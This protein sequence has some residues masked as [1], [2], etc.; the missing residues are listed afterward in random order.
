LLGF[1]SAISIF[2]LINERKK[3]N[4]NFQK[5]KLHKNEVNFQVQ[6]YI[7]RIGP[8]ISRTEN[9]SIIAMD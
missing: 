2:I 3:W 9:I 5:Q 8:G 1:D 7:N 6:N 4:A